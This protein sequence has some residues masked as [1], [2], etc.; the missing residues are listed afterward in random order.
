M[1]KVEL[2]SNT[3]KNGFKNENFVFNAFKLILWHNL[4]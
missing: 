2:G 4:G 1:N 3:A